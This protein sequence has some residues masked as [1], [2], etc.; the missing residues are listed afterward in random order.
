MRGGALDAVIAYISNASGYEDEL[1]AIPV[2]VP[3]ALAVQPIAVGR[4]SKHK[5]L[6][7]RL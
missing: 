4:D 6:T 2:D 1:E 7:E 5:Q 3:C